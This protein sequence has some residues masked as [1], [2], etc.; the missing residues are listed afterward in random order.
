MIVHPDKTAARAVDSCGGTYSAAEEASGWAQGHRDAL[1]AAMRAVKASDD[2]TAE[3]LGACRVAATAE[4][5]DPGTGI[6][7][8]DVLGIV[9]D[10]P[11][12]AIAKAT[13]AT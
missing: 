1:A 13:G 12:A 8:A 6:I 11:R 9:Q 7:D 5:Y 4:L 3:L 2:L 10:V